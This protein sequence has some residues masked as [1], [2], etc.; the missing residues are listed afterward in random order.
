MDINTKIIPG[1]LFEIKINDN[2]LYFLCTSTKIDYNNSI[3]FVGYTSEASLDFSGL[4]KFSFTYKN[5]MGLDEDVSIYYSCNS[6]ITKCT[7]KAYISSNKKGTYIY[8]DSKNRTTTNITHS[9]RLPFN[10]LHKFYRIKDRCSYLIFKRTTKP[11]AD[12]FNAG[13]VYSYKNNYI[14]AMRKGTIEDELYGFYLSVNQNQ[15]SSGFKMKMS[16]IESNRVNNIITAEGYVSPLYFRGIFDIYT[17]GGN[18][19]LDM[20]EIL[21]PYK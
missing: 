17:E 1:D 9:A 21:V 14:I 13:S 7:S 15:Y 10:F 12:I 3:H 5:K 8:K 11:K 2:N 4:N 19:S 6:D 18:P 20:K 16:E